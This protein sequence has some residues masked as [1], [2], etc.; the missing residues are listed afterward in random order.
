MLWDAA[1]LRSS[2]SPAAATR[3]TGKSRE[4][5]QSR[6]PARAKVMYLLQNP[7]ADEGQGGLSEEARKRGDEGI[8]G[9]EERGT[10]CWRSWLRTWPAESCAVI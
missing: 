6:S 4:W 3:F 5:I 7:S 9:D 8:E 10:T 1:S 2:P